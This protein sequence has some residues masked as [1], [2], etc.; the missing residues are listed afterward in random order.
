MRTEPVSLEFHL[1]PSTMISGPAFYRKDRRDF[2]VQDGPALGEQRAAQPK[3][4]SISPE[5]QFLLLVHDDLGFAPSAREISPWTSSVAKRVF[6]S[7]CVV[8]ALPVLLPVLFV[9]G[10]AVGVTSRGPI[11]FLQKRAGKGGR[12][13]TIFKFRTIAHQSGLKHRL[14]TTLH[15]QRFTPIG[16]FLRRWKLDE[17]PQ[18]LNVLLG[19]MSLVGPRP[20]LPEHT[21]CHLAYRPGLTSPAT[22]AFAREESQMAHIPLQQLDEYYHD[23]V[24]P[25]KHWLDASYFARATLLSDFSLVVRTA[26]CRWDLSAA[27]RALAVAG[28]NAAK[29][30]R[31]P[32]RT[33]SCASVVNPLPRQ[34][35]DSASAA[36]EV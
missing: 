32:V 9:V 25:A 19:Q 33:E 4:D 17:L 16:R 7:A 12:T 23:V 2:A 20:K 21:L 3:T 26:L 27:E 8:L 34:T 31:Q 28:I 24:L 5:P 30:Q 18:L 29:T 22:L 36:E 35:M 14:I 6:D 10:I 1:P 11:L 15:N 13:F